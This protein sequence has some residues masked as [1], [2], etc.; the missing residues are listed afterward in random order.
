MPEE[1]KTNKKT[2][3]KPVK[4]ESKVNGIPVRE[5]ITKNE[6]LLLGFLHQEASRI[7]FGQ[8]MVEFTV[9][10]GKIDRMKSSEINRTFN[11][12]S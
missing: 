5:D 11:V 1:K 12:G 4:S 2:E 9:R 8:I 6:K 3:V 7:G 10:N